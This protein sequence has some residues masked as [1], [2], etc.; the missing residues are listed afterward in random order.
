MSAGIVGA[1]ERRARARA[2]VIA[3]LAAKLLPRAR[4]R[5]PAAPPASPYVVADVRPVHVEP[6][7]PAPVVTATGWRG[8]CEAVNP[9][10]GRRCALVA[11]HA[12]PHRHGRTE[13]HLAAAPGQT[14]F[15]RVARL[16]EAASARHGMDAREL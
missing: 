7:P 13:F 14:H 5:K 10:T 9:D 11:G 16:T 2:A 6:P 15:A 8:A 12:A 3:R 4:T 1:E